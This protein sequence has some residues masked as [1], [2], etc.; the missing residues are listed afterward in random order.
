MNIPSGYRFPAEFEP[1]RATW[2]LWPTR[3]DNWRH[4]GYFA[5]NDTLALAALISHFEPVR[6]GVPA[7]HAAKLRKQ[8]PAA[9]TVANVAFNDT[10]VR[11]TGPVTLVSDQYPPI[12]VDW[13]FNSWGGLFSESNED[14][15][16]A[17]EIARYERFQVIRAP[18]VLEGGAVTS[19]GK[20]TIVTTEECALAANRNPGL[21]RSEADDVF[22]KFLNAQNVIW[23]PFGLSHDEAGGH[24]D[25]VCAFASDRVVLVASTNDKSHPSYERL[26]LA[27]EVL[28]RSVNAAGQR[29]SLINV[30]VPEATFITAEEA[31]GFATPQGTIVRA[32]GSP[33]APSY[34]NFY[35]T[36]QA[37]FVP[38]FN[39][40]TDAAAIEIIATAFPDRQTIPC[41]SREFLL[42]GGALHCV[43]KE[44]PA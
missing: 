30:P 44:I 36:A 1:H 21:T 32:A 31:A 40:S 34:I 24:V 8:L 18:I 17:A 22:K 10:W 16:V 9:I 19:D 27:R 3:P 14:D 20:G 12:A 26:R 42:G 7:A 29:F 28:A 39:V 5:Q 37:V 6:V 15:R 2:L 35:P 23:L 38:T 13:K 43:T 41:P 4:N 25:N 11:D 33:L